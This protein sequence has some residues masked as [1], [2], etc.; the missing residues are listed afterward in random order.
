[1]KGRFTKLK[2]LLV[3]LMASS[4]AFAGGPSAYVQIFH[5]CADPAADTVSVFVDFGGGQSSLL[6]SLAFRQATSFVNVPSGT[7]FTVHVKAKGSNAGSPSL[8]SEVLGPL[9]ADSSYVVVASGVVGS[10]FAA[11]PNSVSTAFDLKVLA[12]ARRASFNAG[13]VEFAVFHG[14]TDAPAV[15]VNLSGGATLVPN[16]KFGDASG[17]LSVAP[18]WY[19]ID[20]AAAGTST[21]VASYL[22]DLSTLSGG[23]AVVFA[24]GF[25]NPANNNNG[26][27]FGLFAV[28]ANGTVIE[29]PL[30][31]NANVQVV[32]NCAAP[33]A[34]SVDVYLDGALLLDN[35]KFRTATPFVSVLAGVNHTIAVAPASSTSVADS[36]ATFYDV[37]LE[38]D[39]S[40]TVFASGVVGSGF[41]ANPN[42]VSTT[43]DLK[44]VAPARTASFNAGKVEFAV[45][46]GATDAPAVDVNLTGGATL[47]PNAKYGDA[48]G[49]LSVD[50][51]WYPID[52][53]AAGTS[54]V[55]ASYVADLTGLA[56]GSAIV[57]ASGFLT[58]SAN[59]N[60]PAFG[61]YAVLANGTVLKLPAQQNAK[62]QVVHNCAA[63]AADS[64]DV[65]LDGSLLLDNFKFRT[66]TPFVNVLAGVAHSIAVAPASSTSVGQALA[67][68]PGITLTADSSYTV[69][70]SG[71]VGSG[72]AA[73]PNSVS[74][75]FDLKIVAPAR[76]ASFNAGKVEF[77]VFHGATDAPAVDVNLTGGATLVPNAKYGDASGYLSV[78]PTWYPIDIAAAGTSTVVASYVADLTTLS[79]GAAIVFASGFLTP[80]ANNNGPAFGLFA[81]LG[82]GTVIELPAQ[83]NAQVQVLHNCADPIADSVDVYINGSL[84]LDNFP[85]RTATPFINLVSGY[86]NTVAIAP[87]T[88]TSAASAIWTRDYTL[89]AN[90]KY[91]LT[92]SG[93]VGS[94]FAANPGGYST[95]FDVLVK[96][97]AQSQAVV[98]TNVDF[99]VIHGTTDAPTVD[100]VA[101]NA[102]TVV[103]NAY[104]GTQTAYSQVPAGSY[105]LDV[106]DSSGVNTLV[107][108]V[109]D[110]T[111]LAGKSGVILAS[112]F[113][114]PTTNNNGKAF[115][116]WLALADGGPFIPLAL[117]NSVND[118]KSEIGL[119]MFPNPNS[120][121]MNINFTL[122][123]P[124]AVTI[125]I[126]DLSGKV[127]QEIA[128]GNIL[129]G[130]QNI[131]ADLGSLSSG[132]YV[133]RV[134]TASST[135]NSK[136]SI[137]K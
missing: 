67:T 8:Y 14:S 21:V 22:A 105:R 100:V 127:V 1:M 84:A 66:A 3:A 76:A 107:S 31:Q 70:A 135:A 64:V 109:A 10:G 94:G 99:F 90:T 37:I 42:A 82:D 65:Y 12:P 20:I 113:L 129:S 128:N 46:H 74:T 63:P 81:V 61:L 92:A 40:Y 78:D 51:T 132:M 19:P 123:K 18:T 122:E 134:I 103:N 121:T 24:S 73:N 9:A 29:L 136:F 137:A 85:F 130:R 80:S 43:F 93:V 33:A 95:A 41:A 25:L 131:F 7:S 48:S 60:G 2:M 30:Q 110:V 16:A 69:F 118:F 101:N 125:Q 50:P 27:A 23:A 124:E 97:P 83:E 86:P 115:G 77:A 71:V 119:S 54:T 52:I 11:N 59:N 17:Y 111:A 114:N 72:F 57:F 87:K 58:P 35:F 32:H 13:K 4:F 102:L 106:R 98:S 104:Y 15:D 120:G 116:L 96:T 88:S 126:T 75:A 39:S 49:Y 133:A 28:L 38:A 53:A 6:P 5:N 79:G 44:L 26:P 91:I 112:G 36:I 89:T 108:Y 45:F 55:V 117:F 62:V 68:F 56:G 47:V 34:D